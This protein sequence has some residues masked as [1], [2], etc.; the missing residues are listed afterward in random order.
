MLLHLWCAVAVHADLHSVT[1][2]APGDFGDVLRELKKVIVKD[3][4]VVCVAEAVA[5]LGRLAK[6]LRRDFAPSARA[7]CSVLLDK[8]KDKNSNICTQCD[9][10]LGHFIRCCPHLRLSLTPCCTALFDSH[11]RRGNASARC[12]LPSRQWLEGTD[13]QRAHP[14]LPR[15]CIVL[16]DV[17]ED[18]VAALDHKN[19]KV[20]LCTLRL[21]QVRHCMCGAAWHWMLPRCLVRR[22]ELVA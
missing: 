4:N 6:G 5:C 18:V 1:Q 3:S 2:I 9:E 11:A 10:A 22:S 8:Y 17:V 21:L 7:F 20:K 16:V 15:Y 14:P 19:P 13:S 12:R